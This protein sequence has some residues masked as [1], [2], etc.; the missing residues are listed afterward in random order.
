MV[1]NVPPRRFIVD[2]PDKEL[3]EAVIDMCNRLHIA[4]S[5]AGY[6]LYIAVQ[7]EKD[8][9]IELDKMIEKE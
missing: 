2:V 1:K 6:S 3:K 8:K 7:H 4:G 9:A 5:G